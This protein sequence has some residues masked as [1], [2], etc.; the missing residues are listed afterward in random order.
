MVMVGFRACGIGCSNANSGDIPT[1]S[2]EDRSMG[3]GPT[4]KNS[5]RAPFGME[6]KVLQ[7]LREFAID[8]GVPPG[9]AIRVLLASRRAADHHPPHR[10][11]AAG[12]TE[13][14]LT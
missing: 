9:T 3:R 11:G 10:E 4:L 5:V 2:V 13:G 7:E 6:P 8:L 12:T 1:S 14:E